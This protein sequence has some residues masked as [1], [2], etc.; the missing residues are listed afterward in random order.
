MFLLRSATFAFQIK[1][2]YGEND[3]NLI[4]KS[5]LYISFEGREYLKAWIAERLRIEPAFMNSLTTSILIFLFMSIYSKNL[6]QVF[7]FEI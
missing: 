5:D 1:D 7:K 4:S 6:M 2:A 3:V